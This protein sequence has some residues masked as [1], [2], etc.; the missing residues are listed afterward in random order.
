MAPRDLH[1]PAPG[2]PERPRRGMRARLR[3][4]PTFAFSVRL[5]LAIAATFA[6]LGTAGYLMIGDQLQRRLIDTYAGEHRAD[7]LSFA[8]ARLRSPSSFVAHRRIDDLLAAIARRPGVTEAILI[9]PDGVVEAAGDPSAVGERDMDPRIA[10]AIRHGSAWIGHEADPKD[11]RRDFEFVMPVQLADGRHAFE[12]TRDHELLDSQLRDV[13]RTVMLLVVAGLLGAALVFYLVG[14]RA[15]VR[16]HR[17]A[18]RRASRD[19]L[20]DLPN[21]RAFQ[22]DLDRELQAAVRHGDRLSVASIDLDDF[23]FLN[24]RHGHAHGDALLRRAAAILREL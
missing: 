12:V 20:T 11:D 19:G 5:C 9:G 21:H 8:D 10:A 18:L 7:A 22:E 23:K 6:L 14:G 3:R 15:L 16:S 4:S 17:I 24:D 13:R 1:A 2:R